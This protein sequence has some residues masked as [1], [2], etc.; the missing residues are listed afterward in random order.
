MSQKLSEIMTKSVASVNPSQS[1]QEAAKLMSQHNVGAIPV[2]QNGSV[3]GIVTDR[4]ITLRSVSQGQAP[5]S[6][7][8]ETIMSSNLVTGT[9]EMDVHEAANLMSEKQIRRLPVVDNGQLA[10]IVALGDLA[11]QNIYQNEAGEALSQISTPSSPMA[12]S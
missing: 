3:V 9:P 8:V 4:D 11:T 10:G 6:I 1:I 5:T 2:M 12:T 7:S